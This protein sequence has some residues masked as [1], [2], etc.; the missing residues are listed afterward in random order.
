MEIFIKEK[1]FDCSPLNGLIIQ[2]ENYADS[3]LIILPRNYDEIDLSTLNYIIYGINENN[4]RVSQVLE[5]EISESDVKLKWNI[6][7]DFTCISG[8]INIILEGSNSS[9]IVIK[10][11]GGYIKIQEDNNEKIIMPPLNEIDIALEE[12]KK[13]INESISY[14]EESASILSENKK[15]LESS[16]EL[17]KQMLSISTHPP[18]VGNNNKWLYWNEN[19]QKYVDSGI[20]AKGSKGDKGEPGENGLKGDKGE[21][22]DAGPKG[23]TPVKGTDYF[24]DEEIQQIKTDIINQIKQ[25]LQL[26]EMISPKTFSQEIEKIQLKQEE[27]EKEMKKYCDDAIF[28]IARCL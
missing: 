8:K 26:D 13:N 4:I 21:K 9:G 7:K 6:S 17:H 20:N 24:T 10:F 23:D 11:L 2:G 22:G 12:I 27:R 19:S 5:K 15:V 28:K 18:I 16:K 14:K 1:N 25:E 3:P